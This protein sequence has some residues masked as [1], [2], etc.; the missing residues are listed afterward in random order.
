MWTMIS[1]SRGLWLGDNMTKTEQVISHDFCVLLQIYEDTE[2]KKQPVFFKKLLENSDLS[3]TELNKSLDR[4]YDRAMIDTK[5][6]VLKD[7]TQVVGYV[8]N[9]DFLPFT[10]GLYNASKK[11]YKQDDNM[12]SERTKALK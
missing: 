11:I 3:R 10:K 2:I 7:E 6:F 1:T 4:L 8:V 12:D 5:I 9:D